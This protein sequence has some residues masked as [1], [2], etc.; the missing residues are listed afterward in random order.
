MYLCLQRRIDIWSK[1]IA[2]TKAK[3][4]ANLES[5]GISGSSDKKGGAGE[6]WYHRCKLGLYTTTTTTVQANKAWP[7]QNPGSIRS[8]SSV[9]IP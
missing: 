4:R 5:Y 8:R 9:Q 2:S 7:V 6:P 1:N 3:F